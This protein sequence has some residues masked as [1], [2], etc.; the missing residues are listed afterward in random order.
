MLGHSVH[1]PVCWVLWLAFEH[2]LEDLHHVLVVF[3]LLNDICG[4]LDLK[5]GQLLRIHVRD[6]A[7]RW[8]IELVI[9]VLFLGDRFV[10]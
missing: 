9:V 1:L 6:L 2:Q 10:K 8:Q 7:N 5:C 4:L 3:V